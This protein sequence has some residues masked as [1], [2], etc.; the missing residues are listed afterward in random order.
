MWT[1]RSPQPQTHRAPGGTGGVALLPG[2]AWLGDRRGFGDGAS[3]RGGFALLITSRTFSA[4]SLT[5]F[6]ESPTFGFF[7]AFSAAFRADRSRHACTFAGS[8]WSGF[9]RCT[10]GAY[11]V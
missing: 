5:G 2:F 4:A 9:F 10:S 6:R 8:L 3:T 7:F 11:S 1:A